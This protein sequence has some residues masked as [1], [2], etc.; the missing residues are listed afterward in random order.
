L[1]H[2]CTVSELMAENALTLLAQDGEF[3]VVD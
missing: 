3:E 2:E 1:A